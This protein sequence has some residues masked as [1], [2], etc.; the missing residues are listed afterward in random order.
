MKKTLL[1]IS[2]L[3]VILISGFAKNN[4]TDSIAYAK[5]TVQLKELNAKVD[6]LLKVTDR[7]SEEKNYFSAALSSQTSIF[8]IIITIALALFGVFSFITYKKE[9]ENYN[10]ENKSIIDKQDN[11]INKIEEVNKKHDYDINH[12]LATMYT[13]I[14]MLFETSDPYTCFKFSTSAAA[15]HMKNNFSI[16]CPSLLNGSLKIIESENYYPEIHNKVVNG[17]TGI[18]EEFLELINCDDEAVKNI[19]IKIYRKY[20]EFKEQVIEASPKS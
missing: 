13:A 20:I 14:A 1:I 11:K 2:L 6:S 10:A 17:Y 3:T 12:L 5:Q 18:D 8:G 9:L 4:Q 15:Y 7:L 16:P 19:A